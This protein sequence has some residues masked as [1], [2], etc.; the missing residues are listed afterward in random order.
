MYGGNLL[1]PVD[2]Q[3]W[4]ITDCFDSVNDAIDSAMEDSD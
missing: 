3:V 2:G 4:M 1:F